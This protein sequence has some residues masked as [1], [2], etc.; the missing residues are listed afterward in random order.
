MIPI[1][2][3]GIHKVFFII[4]HP[5]NC[6]FPEFF[7][8]KPLFRYQNPLKFLFR[9]QSYPAS[10]DW[11]LCGTRKHWEKPAS[12]VKESVFWETHNNCR[13]NPMDP[14]PNLP[15]YPPAG[16]IWNFFC[17]GKLSAGLYCSNSS[18][19]HRQSRGRERD[20][21]RCVFFPDSKGYRSDLR[22]F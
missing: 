18:L 13:R 7:P 9:V 5:T 17:A 1:R 20:M 19:F 15:M 3:A 12:S 21:C 4:L 10:A 22:C 2:H 8:R 16:S 6:H 14:F 11:S